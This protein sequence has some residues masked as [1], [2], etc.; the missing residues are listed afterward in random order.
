MII[1]LCWC[2]LWIFHTYLLC[3][4]D[5]VKAHRVNTSN[6]C[7]YLC[8][9][10]S[11]SSSSPV[12]HQQSYSITNLQSSAHISL[13]PLWTLILCTIP[14]IPYPRYCTI[15]TYYNF[16]PH[17]MPIPLHLFDCMYIC[18]YVDMYVSMYLC[19][20]G[21]DDYNNDVIVMMI[22]YVLE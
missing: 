19:I 9:Q 6:L 5:K 21:D 20:D 22:N 10:S 17:L 2:L 7:I 13:S 4:H 16:P 12:S 18:M 3:I 15:S 11:S 8:H 1:I 14:I